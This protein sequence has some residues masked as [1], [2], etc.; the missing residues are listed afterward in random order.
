MGETANQNSMFSNPELENIKCTKIQVDYTEIPN[1]MLT[2]SVVNNGL[3]QSINVQTGINGLTN[4]G[5]S[6]YIN[7]ALQCLIRIQPLMD[8]FLNKLHI[9]EINTISKFGTNGEIAL[10]F[11][12]LAQYYFD[13]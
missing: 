9:Q 8:Y 6:C 10:S 5:N 13:L 7:S 4:F 2:K 3:G 1:H 11:S 12:E